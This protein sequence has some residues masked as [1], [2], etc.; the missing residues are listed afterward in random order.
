MR[1]AVKRLTK[2]DLSFFE[3]QFRRLN[4]R[5]GQKSIN[6]NRDPFVD[7]L[8]PDLP[9]IITDRGGELEVPLWIAGPG[10]AFSDIRI[11]RKI[12]KGQGYKNYRLNGEFVPNPDD[13]DTRFDHLQ[14]DDVAVLAFEGAGQ[15]SRIRLFVLSA[16]EVADQAP[17]A[18]LTPP[19]RPSMVAISPEKL[20]AAIALTPEDHPL[21]SL[22][23]D[24]KDAADLE[25]AA[26]GDASATQRLLNRPVRRPVSA[27]ELAAARRRAEE[28]GR[29]GERLIRDHFESGA[30]G[31][32]DWSWRS[33]ENAIHPWD[34]E[35]N[36]SS[37]ET[38]IEVKSTRG[39]HSTGFH[40]SMAELEAA[41]G[42]APYHIYRVSRLGPE[43]G[44][45][46]IAED[47]G[48]FAGGLLDLMAGLPA[49]V[50]PD[51]FTVDP[52]LLSWSDAVS[53][54]WLDVDV[55]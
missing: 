1:F 22:F 17:L 32:G 24:P 27:E 6:L 41:A 35:L 21:R 3:P 31:D 43:G 34:F 52:G 13:A 44:E 2:S 4:K 54:A 46:Q 36:G 40:I 20:S 23:L 12:S 11:A 55:E 29:E 51:G 28:T 16:A 33:A 47:F 53:L 42:G 39:A 8:Y 14:P 15:P 10:T 45:L 37:G 9:D 38:R 25:E 48:R 5:S 19:E 50:R 18:A 49:G 30:A 26:Q 7:V